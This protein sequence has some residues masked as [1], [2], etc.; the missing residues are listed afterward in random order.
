[1]SSK[2]Q[3]RGAVRISIKKLLIGGEIATSTYTGP[4]EVLLA[5]SVLGDVI[6]LRLSGPETWKVGRDGFLAATSGINK[7]Y[8]SQGLMK[9]VF[10][11]EGLFIYKMS[12]VGIVWVQSFGAIIKKDVSAHNSPIMNSSTELINVQLAEDESYYIDNGH[13]VA[14][15]CKYEMRQITSG[16]IISG[17]AASEGL[18]CKFTGPGTVYLQTRNLNAFGVQ[19]GAS[20]ASG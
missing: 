10:S 12:G 2:V 15:N 5:P 19:I 1:M 4:G 7:D 8:Q 16:G 13:L 18:A 11:G 3:L 20:T 14:W 6:A 9:G 17:L